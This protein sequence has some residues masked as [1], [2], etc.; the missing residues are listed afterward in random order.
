MTPS[1]NRQA[2]I[3]GLF[4]AAAIAILAGGILTIG[5]INDTF[6]RKVTV[7]A[8]FDEVSGLKRGDNVWFS[9]VKVGIVS[10]L[11]FS[12]ASQVQVTMKIDEAATP[13]I[14]GDS[15]ATI[16]SD[17]LIGSRIVVLQGGTPGAADLEEGDSLAM[18]PTVST[19][20]LLATL[21]ENNTNLVAITGNVKAITHRLA[22]GEGTLG[23]LLDDETLY[24]SLSDTTATL[25]D[26]SANARV[27]TA[28]LSSFASELNREGGLPHDLATDRTSYA[29][30]VGTV[31]DLQKTGERASTLVDGLAR[32]ATESGTPIGTLLNDEAAGTDVKATLDNLH[33]GSVLLT[34]DLEA[35]QH[36]FLFRGYFRKQERARAREQARADRDA[37]A[38]GE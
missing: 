34:E 29:V 4:S 12:G 8:V 38:K 28:S 31:G 22:A 14:R 7:T 36:N 27:L 25:S 24:A 18:G 26:A 19:E 10:A 9:G 35:F 20:A 17:G 30:L 11:G 15:L 37:V 33:R 13:F 1:P 32:A 3:V 5:D 6:T 2:V 23:K 16:G 21:Q